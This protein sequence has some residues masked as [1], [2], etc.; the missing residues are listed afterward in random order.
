MN[1]AWICPFPVECKLDDHW[2]RR[3]EPEALYKRTQRACEI[4]GLPTWE[5]PFVS[6]QRETLTYLPDDPEGPTWAAVPAKSG[7]DDEDCDPV[8]MHVAEALIIEHLRTWLIR[9]QWQIQ[10]HVRQDRQ[11][12]RLV[13]CLVVSEGGGDRLDVDY[14]NGRDELTVMCESVEAVACGDIKYR[15]SGP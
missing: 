9:R 11:Q 15:I 12:W 5:S 3:M 4:A 7:W 10:V 2:S 6:G 14:P 8:A 13:D 1:A